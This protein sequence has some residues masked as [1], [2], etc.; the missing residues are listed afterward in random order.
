MNTHKRLGLLVALVCCLV[1][2]PQVAG[3]NSLT[4]KTDTI[5][6]VSVKYRIPCDDGINAL[7]LG[8]IAITLAD[9]GPSS[10]MD[11]G[12]TVNAGAQ[13]DLIWNC[14]ELHWLQTI[15]H[16]DCPAKISGKDPVLPIID[17]PKGG[18][19]Y[20]Y[21]DGAARKDPNMTIPNFGWFIDDQ[22]WYYNSTGE[23]AKSDKGK[24]YDITDMPGDC[25]DP[26]WTGFSSYL[27]ATVSWECPNA[28]PDCLKKNEM[29]LLA[30]FDWTTSS[31]D[32]DITDTFKAP[33]PFD[34][35]DITTALSNAGFSGW[36]VYDDK[37]ICC[38]IPEPMTI[39]GLFLGISWV[40]AYVRKRVKWV[41]TS[42]S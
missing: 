41:S 20:M 18:W 13:G 27:M 35:T 8:D 15:W 9:A 24:T 32:I 3:G 40:G 17:P 31:A 37:V 4:T 33:S 34:V 10:R 39:F 26:N 12:L 42:L 2:W 5:S 23:A 7:N 22:P 38:Y 1:L 36:T 19:D 11:A 21:K 16:D 28:L 30:G 29:L 14:L 25:I 6:D